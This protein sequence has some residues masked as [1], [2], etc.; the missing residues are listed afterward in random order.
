MARHKKDLAM[1]QSSLNIEHVLK[2][3]EAEQEAVEN[4]KTYKGFCVRRD[5]SRHIHNTTMEEE[6]QTASFKPMVLEFISIICEHIPLSIEAAGGRYDFS[7]SSNGVSGVEIPRVIELPKSMTIQ[8]V[9]IPH[10]RSQEDIETVGRRIQIAVADLDVHEIQAGKDVLSQ[11]LPVGGWHYV[12][13]RLKLI[14]FEKD[15]IYEEYCPQPCRMP[16][17]PICMTVVVVK[18]GKEKRLEP[19]I[20]KH[21]RKRESL[22][23]R[24]S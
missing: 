22:Q 21:V 7:S 13:S 23:V 6:D 4:L 8:R 12:K 20:Q 17:C 15:C 3:Q 11:L 24:T 9:R 18:K 5:N 19:E 2:E 16:S 1:K 10:G 14:N